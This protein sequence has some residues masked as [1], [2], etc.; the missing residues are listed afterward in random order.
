MKEFWRKLVEPTRRELVVIVIQAEAPE[1]L[2]APYE[3]LGAEIIKEETKYWKAL[4]RYIWFGVV[5]YGS[6]T[7]LIF[8]ATPRNTEN[9]Y[10]RNDISGPSALGGFAILATVIV[11]LQIAVRTPI[12][13]NQPDVASIL[14]RQCQRSSKSR[15]VTLVEK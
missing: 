13:G 6:M 9:V 5:A 7:G 11:A 1:S 14:A 12:A 2:T 3:D 10:F 4:R 15:P 8:L